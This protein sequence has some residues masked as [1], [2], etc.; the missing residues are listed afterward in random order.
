MALGGGAR[1]G[2]DGP[3]LARSLRAGRRL[4]PT[5]ANGF[6]VTLWPS[7]TD[8]LVSSPFHQNPLAFTLAARQVSD[9]LFMLMLARGAD[10]HKRI[11]PQKVDH[12]RTHNHNTPRRLPAEPPAW[13]ARLD[14]P[15]AR[16]ADHRGLAAP[17]PGE[18]DC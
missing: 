11:R 3:A 4:G 10:R 14:H 9:N 6:L 13:N 17:L 5:F 8:P 18:V 1:L 7:R 15:G 16:Q 2:L 12:G